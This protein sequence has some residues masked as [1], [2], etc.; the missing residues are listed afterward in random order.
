MAA[1][2]K[3]AETF[4]VDWAGSGTTGS[5]TATA[6]RS[7]SIMRAD[8]LAV[9]D[10]TVVSIRTAC[11]TKTPLHEMTPQGSRT[12]AAITRQS[13][14]SPRGL[15]ALCASAPAQP[16]RSKG[17]RRREG[18]GSYRARIGNTG[19][20]SGP[21]LHFGRRRQGRHH[22]AEPAFVASDGFTLVGTVDNRIPRADRLVISPGSQ[23]SSVR[24][25]STL[26]AASRIT[27]SAT[28]AI[29]LCGSGGDTALKPRRA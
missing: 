26:M 28:G 23:R 7:S 14:K 19:P 25:I 4:A 29:H 18:R 15:R 21:H 27:R 11:P 5:S 6:R 1:A 2:S 17:R 10:G 3:T 16:L 8:V 12:M 22:W 20:S 9:A 24:I 13:S